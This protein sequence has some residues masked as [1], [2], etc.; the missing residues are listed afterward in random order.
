MPGVAVTSRVLLQPGARLQPATVDGGRRRAAVR[1]TR[2]GRDVAAACEELDKAVT[3]PV[4]LYD[5]VPIDEGQDL[6]PAFYR[7]ALKAQ[8]EPKR[9]FWAYCVRAG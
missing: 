7:L 9:L 4:D 6:P 2:S 8:R 1:Y 3:A 5:A